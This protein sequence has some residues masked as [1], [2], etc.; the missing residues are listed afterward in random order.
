MDQ[1]HADAQAEELLF[2]V[3]FLNGLENPPA[4]IQFL[5]PENRFVEEE[6]INDVV[7]DK[8]SGRYRVEPGCPYKFQVTINRAEKLGFIVAVIMGR[9]RDE[10]EF[11]NVFSYPLIRDNFGRILHS[12][13]TNNDSYDLVN[14]LSGHSNALIKRSIHACGLGIAFA[15]FL[16]FDDEIAKM[17]GL[18][19]L[20]HEYGYLIDPTNHTA[21][22]AKDLDTSFFMVQNQYTTIALNIIEHHHAIRPHHS[23]YVNCGKIV[24]HWCSHSKQDFTER[25]Q[26]IRS[27]RMM[28]SEEIYIGF[29]KLYEIMAERK[30]N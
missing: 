14:R 7:F 4:V 20:L 18:G 19:G 10:M 12:T 6:I 11:G 24:I 8:I 26:S 16:E 5:D 28:Y 3:E 23:P 22:G 30:P 25:M 9:M 21:S 13:L 27:R 2:P 1:N 17:I 15:L 29:R